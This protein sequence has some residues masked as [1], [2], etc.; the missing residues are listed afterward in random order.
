MEFKELDDILLKDGRIA[1]VMSI[2]G[3]DLLC[4]DIGDTPE[5]WDNIFISTDEVVKILKRY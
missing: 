3:K 2:A 1:T 4:V 5:T